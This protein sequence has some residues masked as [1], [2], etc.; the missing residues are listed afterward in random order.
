MATFPSLIQSSVKVTKNNL[1][2][3]LEI[4]KELQNGNVYHLFLTQSLYI[5]PKGSYRKLL[6]EEIFC[7][8][9]KHLHACC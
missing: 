4:Y 5:C 6:K 3:G 9:H 7:N 8:K 2:F 1:E